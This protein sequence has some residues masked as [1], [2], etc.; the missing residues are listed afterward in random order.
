M[1]S[2]F[3]EYR[4]ARK[5]AALLD[6]SS[7]G[8]VEV[9]GSDAVTFLHNLATNDFKNL[10]PGQGCETFLANATARV[11]AHAFVYRMP[12]E[13][14][15][16]WLDLTPGQAEKVVKHLD[17]FLISEQVEL[18]DRTQDF[19][20]LLLVG[21]EARAILVRV[22]GDKLPALEN[23]QVALWDFGGSVGQV[24]RNDSLGLPG[25]SLLCT[26]TT[27]ESLRSKLTETGA[28]LAGQEVYEVLR[29]E[30]GLP[31]HGVDVEDTTFAP[32][33]GRTA[34]AISYTKG[35][36]LGQEPIVMARDRGQVNRVLLGV[37]LQDGPVPPGSL[38]Y[39]DGKEVGRVTSSLVSPRFETAI[40]LAYLRRGHQEPGTV[41]EV[42]VKGE[43]RRA[44]V[45]SLPF[46]E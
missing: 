36:Y 23:L 38:L 39:R 26:P 21:P 4:H 41:L 8:K 46:A 25:Y 14:P 35:C 15:T 7:R 34:R 12:V 16:F 22:L 13:P 45:A 42:E 19:A 18:V 43:R 37:K 24:R 10:P 29:V 9:A 31:V 20:Q 40:G 32:E 3:D 27:A 2:T 30:A 33:V 44:E 5:D 28:S 6:Q 11:I 17:H 1:T